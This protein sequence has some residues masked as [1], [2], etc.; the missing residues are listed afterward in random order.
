[1]KRLFYVIIVLLFAGSVGARIPGQQKKIS[2]DR[3]EFSCKQ[4]GSGKELTIKAMVPAG[5]K[6]NTGFGT[7]LF[8][9]P[10]A[11]DYFDPP[12]IEFQVLS[13]GEIKAEAMPGNIEGYIERLKKG[14]KKLATG[15]PEL[16]EKGTIVTVNK[17]ETIPGRWLLDVT[18]TYPEGV[19]SAMYPPRHWIYVFLHRAQDP[20]LMLIK[21][22]V[23][24]SLADQ[25][26]E[27]VRTACLSKVSY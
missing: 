25:F 16:D 27:R 14:W 13:E 21:G 17:E 24:V 6:R 23:P 7:V 8:Q 1:M 9:P 19:S 2:G 15:N 26:L 18:L 12:N 3:V 22:C 11:G 5:W 10:D 20:Y 4:P